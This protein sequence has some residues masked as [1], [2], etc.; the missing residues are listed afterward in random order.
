MEDDLANLR[1]CD[2]EEKAFQ[3]EATVGDQD[4]RLC[5]VDRCLTDSVVHFPSLR[6]TM[7]DVWN[8]VGGIC[9]S[10]LGDKRH[11]FQ[12]FHE[13]D[14]QRVLLGTP[15]FF[16]NHLF[17]LQKVQQG[18]HPSDVLL[19]FTEFWIQIHDLPPGLM[20]EHMARQLGNFFG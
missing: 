17:I 8:P 9:I 6:N 11:L 18:E 13:I 7:A 14:T 1:L 20:T 19:N 4:F 3:E 10:D 16:N 12:F 15:W 5:L 2:E